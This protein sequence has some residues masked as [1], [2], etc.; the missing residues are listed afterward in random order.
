MPNLETA[1][2]SL[3]MVLGGGI[4][5]QYLLTLVGVPGTGK[6]VLAQQI[7]LN[8]AKSGGKVFFATTL[9]E[10]HA[11]LL[12]YMRGFAF[13]DASLMG[14]QVVLVNLYSLLKQGVNEATLT[15]TKTIKDESATLL[16]IDSLRGMRDMGFS[17][18]EVS[19][20]LY[21]L[22]GTLSMLN[23]TLIALVD[24]AVEEAIGFPE[25]AI[26]DGIIALHNERQGVHHRRYLEILKMR[27]MSYLKGLH[28]MKIGPEGVSVF[29][30]PELSFEGARGGPG[31][32]RVALGVAPL[33]EMMHGGPLE[34]SA[35]VLLGPPG[36]G[37]TL[38]SLYFVAEGVRRGEPSLLMSFQESPEEL[39][40][41]AC[42]LGLPLDEALASGRLE[43][44]SLRPVDVDP[45][46]L[47]WRLKGKI[48]DMGIRRLALDGT[49]P[50]EWPLL[51][52]D[53]LEE[54]FAAL[55]GYLKG[56][57][58][59]SCLT[60]EVP[61]LFDSSAEPDDLG[62]FAQA[63]NLVLLRRT[64][65]EGK[66]RYTIAVLKM[67][68]SQHDRSIKQ[69]AFSDGQFKLVPPSQV[70]PFETD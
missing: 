24:Y 22:S 54:Y 23:C 43:I 59:T 5:R 15:L 62:H 20:F 52:M 3:D 55:I 13:F 64:E 18:E 63:D 68:G 67:R 30:W 69:Y 40:A 19:T 14:E 61:V 41:R 51:A 29:P 31:G 65:A 58:V 36:V 21:E 8:V 49:A 46:E 10:P 26:A 37:K 1:I 53:R 34:G 6:T 50:V 35:T 47:A 16:I 11:K 28:S 56:R 39:R 17:D 2:P 38:L 48:E 12:A 33:D 7:A 45:D 57:G 42:S 27:G 66:F 25:L 4:P 70:T 32:E 60:R 44:M 9:S